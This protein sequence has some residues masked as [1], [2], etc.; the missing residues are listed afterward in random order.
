M[1]SKVNKLDIGKLGTTP[2]DLSKLSN[3]V[4]NDVVEKTKYNELVKKVNNI[5]TTDTSNL[6]KK[7][8]YNIKISEIEN[9]INDH[10]YAKYITAQGFNKL[11]SKN[12]ASRLSQATLGSKNDIANFVNNTDFDDKLK[13]LNKKVTSNKTKHVLVENEL[14]ELSE[15][16]KGVSTKRLTININIKIKINILNGGKYF[17]SGISQNYFVFIPAKKC[18]KYFS[19]TTQIYL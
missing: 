15:K 1:K 14:N 13:R 6:V 10:D 16:V 12:F 9:K 7:T 5:N 4:K 19:D 11:I 3:V 17:Y 18:I 2:A 8:D